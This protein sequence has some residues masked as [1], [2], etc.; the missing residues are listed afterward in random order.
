METKDENPQFLGVVALTE[1]LPK[2]RDAEYGIS[3]MPEFWGQD[4]GTEATKFMANYAFVSLGMHRVTLW[5]FSHNSA[6]LALYKK[7]CIFPLNVWATLHTEGYSCRGFIEEG[8]RR[9][10]TW[11]NGKWEDLIAMGILE[12]EWEWKVSGV[13]L[14]LVDSRVFRSKTRSCISS[15]LPSQLRAWKNTT[16]WSVKHKGLLDI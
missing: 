14:R 6:A 16:D 3:L 2:N 11:V 4:Y 15:N 13:L 10:S 5:T 12:D 1:A 9:K 8:R 7:V